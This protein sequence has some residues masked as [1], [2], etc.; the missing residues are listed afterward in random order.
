MFGR[1]RRSADRPARVREGLKLSPNEERYVLAETTT[2]QVY[3][4]PSA[5]RIRGKLRG[6]GDVLAAIQATC[7]N[8][9]AR[10]CGFE[11]GPDGTFTKYI[12]DRATVHLEQRTMPGATD[13]ELR[14]AV[15][16]HCLKKGDL[17]PGELHRYIV[18]EIGEDDFVFGMALHH[19]T[20]DG[21][22]QSAFGLELFA[23]F[24][25]LPAP[26]SPTQY[27]DVW[28][29]DWEQSQAYRD[30]EAFWLER[31][32]G[33]GETASWPADRPPSAERSPCGSAKA[34][35]CRRR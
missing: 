26:Q 24:M 12:D 34:W 2:G 31:L 10:R 27:S 28:N 11:A 21:M 15:N 14:E 4:V 3:A 9:E 16:S 23:R 5:T 29:F 32:E 6:G 20:S 17:S 7:D 35:R 1:W 13:D 30:A 19:A 33:W 8:H 25:D 18:I 22:T